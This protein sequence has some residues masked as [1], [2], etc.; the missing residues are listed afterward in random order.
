MIRNLKSLVRAARDFHASASIQASTI[1]SGSQSRSDAAQDHGYASSVIHPTTTLSTRRR[2]EMYLRYARLP[3]R[4]NSRTPSGNFHLPSS[5]VQA[6]YPEVV[7]DDDVG[8]GQE[9]YLD[10]TLSG[11]FSK[12]AQKALRKFDFPKAEKV[13]RQALD[14]HKISAPDDAHHS[15]LRTQLAICGFLQGKGSEIEDAVIDLAEFRGTKRSVAHQLLYNLALSLMHD[16]DFEAA[17]KICVK[18]WA[19]LSKPEFSNHVKKSDLFRLLVISYRESDKALYAEALEEQHPELAT[20]TDDGLPSILDSVI[21]CEELLVEFLGVDDSSEVPR[22]FIHQLRDRVELGRK[23]PFD[24]R[25]TK[26]QLQRSADPGR[27]SSQFNGQEETKKPT[28]LR[29]AATIDVSGNHKASYTERLSRLKTVLRWRSTQNKANSEASAVASNDTVSHTSGTHKAIRSPWMYRRAKTSRENH[30][31]MPLWQRL[32]PL[33]RRR[34][35]RKR[36]ENDIATDEN[37]H[38]I[39][40]W[41]HG[42]DNNGKAQI[43]TSEEAQTLDGVKSCVCRRFSFVGMPSTPSKGTQPAH[44]MA[45]MP[46]TCLF[47]M[48]DTSPRVE[49]SDTGLTPVDIINKHSHFARSPHS[50]T[51]PHSASTVNRFHTTYQVSDFSTSYGAK[52]NS[53]TAYQVS[54]ISD[55]FAAGGPPS[56]SILLGTRDGSVSQVSCPM[57]LE[58]VDE[59][60]AE[61]SGISMVISE[62]NP[63]SLRRERPCLYLPIHYTVIS[64]RTLISSPTRS[65]KRG[66][67]GARSES[68]TWQVNNMSSAQQREDGSQDP[69]HDFGDKSLLEAQNPDPENEQSPQGGMMAMWSNLRSSS[70]ATRKLQRHNEIQSRQKPGCISNIRTRL[71][72]VVYKNDSEFSGSGTNR[73]YQNGML[74]EY[75]GPTAVAGPFTEQDGPPQSSHKSPGGVPMFPDKPENIRMPVELDSLQM[76][77]YA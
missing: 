18:L 55:S 8:L 62:P 25:W 45:E 69:S 36:G 4:K 66:E 54:E 14:R 5:P 24:V 53:H 37:G 17:H 56:R 49:L 43:V 52:A 11:G 48:M 27:P 68:L 77:R 76:I 65:I 39:L 75:S 16:L 15:R 64:Q 6:D 38:R 47:E 35:L 19:N 21:N 58:K 20:I 72:S 57:L 34:M 71:K 23:T 40:S 33:H 70:Q 74:Y 67:L 51:T 41:M 63:V 26:Q 31:E 30:N 59:G 13:L 28:S 73:V 50:A 44:V 61:Q 2:M 22:L 10:S 7:A 32:S 3:S 9:N 29:K 1:F 60:E 12:M 46:D 42:Q